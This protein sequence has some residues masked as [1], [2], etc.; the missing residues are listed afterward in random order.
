MIFFGFLL[1]L[2]C[3]AI[4]WLIIKAIVITLLVCAGLLG[5]VLL[6]CK[7]PRT[8][9]AITSVVIL[10]VLLFRHAHGG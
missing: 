5:A 9:S 7:A 4:A 6:F 3:C 10:G 2:V 8:M 1:F